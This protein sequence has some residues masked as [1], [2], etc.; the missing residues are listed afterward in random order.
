MPR[1][2]GAN[3]PT[4]TRITAWPSFWPYRAG[5]TTPSP[6]TRKRCGSTRTTRRRM[7]ALALP[8]R[9]RGRFR[10]RD[11]GT[12]ARGGAESTICA[13]GRPRDAPQHRARA[14]A[15]L[16]PVDPS[17]LGAQCGRQNRARRFERRPA[18][19]GGGRTW[20]VE[21]GRDG[22]AALIVAIR[23]VD[24][25]RQ[26]R[27]RFARVLADGVAS[28]EIREGRAPGRHVQRRRQQL[29]HELQPLITAYVDAQG[30]QRRMPVVHANVSDRMAADAE[31]SDAREDLLRDVGM[32]LVEARGSREERRERRRG[33]GG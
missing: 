17:G 2:S 25:V 21:R 12:S 10:G 22:G 19:A 8:W 15:R 29:A 3:P 18:G 6:S 26:L 5:P 24:A 11:A 28:R 1:R 7:P 23:L 16:P 4:P 9:D 20:R 27:H 30:L 13:T 33:R 32:V 14:S 31:P